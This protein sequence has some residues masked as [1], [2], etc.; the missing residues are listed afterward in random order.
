MRALA[1]LRDIDA[2]VGKR[3]SGRHLVKKYLVL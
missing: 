1:Q 2:D 3:P